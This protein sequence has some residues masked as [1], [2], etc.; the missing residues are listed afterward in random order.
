[1]DL[2]KTSK[3]LPFILLIASFIFS[4]IVN[5]KTI[6]IAQSCDY[7][8]NHILC[9]QE[10]LHNASSCVKSHQVLVFTPGL[11]RVPDT[12]QWYLFKDLSNVTLAANGTDNAIIDCSG[13]AAFAFM[14][15]SQL[16]INHITF[17]N[18]GLNITKDIMKSIYG[19]VYLPFRIRKGQ[20]VSIYL[21]N[22]YNF[23]ADFLHVLNSSG[24]GL[25]AINVLG[26]SIVQ[27][28]FFNAS[29]KKLLHNVTTKQIDCTNAAFFSTCSGG[30]AFFL[31]T[32]IA[33]Q[34]CNVRLSD[35]NLTVRKSIF[36]YGFN[37]VQN[38]SFLFAHDLATGEDILIGGGLSI[39]LVQS[40][41][42]ANVRAMDNGFHSN[43]AYKGANIHIVLYSVV[44]MSSVEIAT[45]TIFSGNSILIDVIKDMSLLAKGGGIYYEYGKRLANDSARLCPNMSLRSGNVTSSFHDI[46]FKDNHAVAGGAMLVL[47]H[48]PP[49]D[50]VSFFH[51]L[52]LE[53]LLFNTNKGYYGAALYFGEHQYLQVVNR[54]LNSVFQSFLSNISANEN[55]QLSQGIRSSVTTTMFFNGLQNAIMLDEVIITDNKC[56]GM[57]IVNSFLLCRNVLLIG[58]K[59]A[60][61]GGMT[62]LGNSFL[63]LS[64]NS[65]F[66]VVNNTSQDYGGGIYIPFVALTNDLQPP[67]FFQILPST[68]VPNVSSLF[69]YNASIYLSGNKAT[70]GYDIYGGS[71]NNCFLIYWDV[72]TET[73]VNEFIHVFNYSSVSPQVTSHATSVCFCENNQPKC[74]QKSKEVQAYPGEYFQISAVPVGQLDGLTSSNDVMASIPIGEDLRL[75]SKFSKPQRLINSCDNLK[76]AILTNKDTSVEFDLYISGN[77]QEYY[78]KT[79]H[80]RV[81]S[82]PPF[83]THSYTEKMC[84]CLDILQ[85]SHNTVKCYLRY[86]YIYLKGNLYAGYYNNCVYLYHNCP[87]DYCSAKDT[88][89]SNERQD[90]QCANNRIG[91]LCGQ[92]PSGYSLQLGSNRCAPCTNIFLFLLL[93]FALAGIV[94][95]WFISFFNLTVSIGALNGLIFYA[96]IVHVNKQTLYPS[97]HMQSPLTIFIAWLNLDLSIETCFF[98]GLNQFSK[99][100]LQFVFPV[101]L[102]LLAILAIYLSRKFSFMHRILGPHSTPAL[103]TIFLLSFTKLLNNNILIFSLDRLKYQCGNASPNYFQIWLPDANIP[104][105]GLRHG[106]LFALALTSALFLILP[107]SLLL[108]GMPWLQRLTHFRLLRWIVRLKPFLDA[109]M[110]PFNNNSRYW[111]GFLL[112]GRTLVM[113]G[114]SLDSS[115]SPHLNLMVMS[116]C[117]MVLA[118]FVLSGKGIYRQKILNFYEAFAYLNLGSYGLMVFY[119]I[120]QDSDSSKCQENA[121]YVSLSIAAVQFAIVV[122]IY[123]L[124]KIFDMLGIKWSNCMYSNSWYK[125]LRNFN[126]KT[127]GA[128][129]T[130]SQSHRSSVSVKDDNTSDASRIGYREPL[131]D[132]LSV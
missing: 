69:D 87:F 55:N 61:G 33:N 48:L 4:Q 25:A 96:N 6:L 98:D 114:F 75:L 92:C 10:C 101:Y 57:V 15:I 104:Y 97:L 60:Y 63:F 118:M 84:V 117:V 90:E 56:I 110:G 77:I 109:Y 2:V 73:A 68:A 80:V 126:N 93:P 116:L 47:L 105:L 3:N 39:L 59:G 24:I 111:A 76:F 131:L 127:Y 124:K 125:P 119:C 19:L 129:S 8:Q 82:C 5:G 64:P 95:V 85:E 53:H 50:N 30:N 44:H 26:A 20:K 130:T 38:M 22:V 74:Y 7:E 123:M 66:T 121:T 128:V 100:L 115:L 78:R 106:I 89:I 40:T 88:L 103:A 108:F 107:Y 94:L 9:L 34:N 42:S 72:K 23:E 70:D 45:S 113:I 43:V 16:S 99:T 58:N 120:S 46:L 18:C 14:N 31:Y 86:G 41:Y 29:N 71:L 32:E 27:N 37:Y 17:Q 28:S 36:Q 79:V 132:Y 11:H 12:S 65:L 54:K 51:H 83:F 91:L 81:L 52:R 62:L 122:I 112:F 49:S 35:S 21:V 102:W 13:Q 1:M 67:C